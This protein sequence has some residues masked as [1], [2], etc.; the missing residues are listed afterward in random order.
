MYTFKYTL[1]S[2][3]ELMLQSLLFSFVKIE[4]R[5]SVSMHD[6]V[7]KHC[8]LLTVYTRN[9]K[10]MQNKWQT[11]VI[12][13]SSCGWVMWH[14]SVGTKATHCWSWLLSHSRFSCY[15]ACAKDETVHVMI[16]YI[17][18]HNFLCVLLCITPNWWQ[19]FH[20]SAWCSS[21]SLFSHCTW[22]AKWTFSRAV[23]WRR[24]L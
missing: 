2:M 10:Q 15:V 18:T 1:V 23:D 16:N 6:V 20:L 9:I 22:M 5:C 8:C 17:W 24:K 12:Y 7:L 21:T 13:Y 3:T 14:C 11:V 4:C 19:T